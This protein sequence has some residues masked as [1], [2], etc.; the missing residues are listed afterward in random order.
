MIIRLDEPTAHDAVLEPQLQTLRSHD[1]TDETL[2][3]PLSR[4][5]SI[6]G[7][8][9]RPIEPEDA[10]D[11]EELRRFI[12][13]ELGRFRY[14]LGHLTCT[15]RPANDETFT[16]CWVGLD[17]VRADGVDEP[18]PIAWS[19]QPQRLDEPVE[20]STTIGL[21]ASLKL[22]PVDIGPTLERTST[23][24]HR[25]VYLQAYDEQESTPC[26]ELYR[27]QSVPL[28]GMQRLLVVV[29][30]PAG[31]EIDGTARVQA[32]V[33]GRR[34]VL[35]PYEATIDGEKVRRFRLV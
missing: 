32:K 18:A 13:E 33:R 17:L 24:T 1:E 20:I 8:L 31:A 15:F 16:E 22:P 5:L 26:W 34:G 23:R 14:H 12:E 11:D 25:E 30:S 21:G 29:R 3:M 9:F 28:R 27:T 7:P 2:R 6:G 35:L 19:M 4:R 10:D